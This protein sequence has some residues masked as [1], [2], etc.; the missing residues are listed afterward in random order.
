MRC[1]RDARRASAVAAVAAAGLRLWL[2]CHRAGGPR[3][4]CWTR[5]SCQRIPPRRSR[6]SQRDRDRSA[7]DTRACARPARMIDSDAVNPALPWLAARF[8]CPPW[9]AAPPSYRPSRLPTPTRVSRSPSL[10]CCSNLHLLLV[11]VARFRTAARRAGPAGCPCGQR[12]QS[13]PPSHQASAGLS[14]ESVD[15]Q[16]GPGA[17]RAVRAGGGRCA[18]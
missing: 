10:R 15:D 5:S 16:E 14:S 12:R 8:L 3:G 2:G 9:S 18:G 17:S 6:R 4:P 7:N 11:L 1:P 13:S